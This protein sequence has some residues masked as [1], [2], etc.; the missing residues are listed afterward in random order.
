MKAV[1]T[2]FGNPIAAA[3][4]NYEASWAAHVKPPRIAPRS[5]FDQPHDWGFHIYALGSYMM[6]RGIAD[7]VEFWD[8]AEDRGTRYHSNGI[9]RVMFHNT[10]DVQAY[11]NR[12]G[13]P[14]LYVNHG[15]GGQPILDL[16]ANRTFRVHV[17]ALRQGRDR[18]G[19]TAAECY[20][21]DSEEFFDER[22]MMYVPVVHTRAIYPTGAEKKWDFIYLASCYKGKRHDLLVRA[23]RESGLSGHLHPVSTSDL[24][25]AGTRITTTEFNEAEVQDVLNASR[26]AVYPADKTSSPASMW[27]CV[28]AGLPIVVNENILG[29]KHLVVSGV[30]GE[31]ASEDE[32]GEV[33][34]HVVENRDSY[35]PRA[36]FE[37]Q[38]DTVETLE[39]YVRF[40]KQMGW[41]AGGVFASA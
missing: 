28:A 31:L 39:S 24:D 22:C 38:W 7:E 33:M 3:G 32:F 20:L 36:Y 27:E 17:P 18:H 37:S 6:N 30:T 9:L 4:L 29:G 34:R 19:N 12:Y 1:I 5:L 16:L 26:I 15:S 2:N 21:V 11:L 41:K 40:F 10:D 14:D 13:Y 23:A 8:F 25:L 35:A